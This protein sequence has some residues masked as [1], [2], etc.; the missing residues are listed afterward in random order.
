VPYAA[1]NQTTTTAKTASGK[2]NFAN[3]A[4]KEGRDSICQGGHIQHIQKLFLVF[5]L[6]S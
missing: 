3:E 2:G 6:V 5:E 1:A 4:R